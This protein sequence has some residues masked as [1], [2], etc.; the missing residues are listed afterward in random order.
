MTTEAIRTDALEIGDFVG[1]GTGDEPD[2]QTVWLKIAGITE[3]EN[4]ERAFQIAYSD[5]EQIKMP[6]RASLVRFTR[7]DD[8]SD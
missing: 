1:F 5:G 7:R 3:Q 8:S 4:G 2:D 6:V